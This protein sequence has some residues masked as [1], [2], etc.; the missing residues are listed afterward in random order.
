MKDILQLENNLQFFTNVDKKH[1]LMREALKSIHEQHEA[2]ALWEDK[3]KELRLREKK[4]E[5]E[6]LAPE[7]PESV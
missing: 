5:E 4:E 6:V 2:L 7:A 3:L 1:P